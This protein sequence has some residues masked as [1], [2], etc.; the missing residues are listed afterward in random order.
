MQQQQQQQ[1]QQQMDFPLMNPGSSLQRRHTISFTEMDGFIPPSMDYTGG[2]SMMQLD[3]MDPSFRSP[4]DFA[5]PNISSPTSSPSQQQP[6]AYAPMIEDDPQMMLMDPNAM[7]HLLA[8]S[9]L[10]WG[11]GSLD[12]DRKTEGHVLQ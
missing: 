4:Q 1:Q 6:N 10:S 12:M 9:T 2:G 5:L 7:H 11:N 8:D 3:T